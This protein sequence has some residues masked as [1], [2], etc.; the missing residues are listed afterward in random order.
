MYMVCCRCGRV[1]GEP[2]EQNLKYRMCDICLG[3]KNEPPP[4]KR[5]AEPK[6]LQYALFF[7]Y[8]DST[9]PYL[10]RS[11][12]MKPTGV[13]CPHKDSSE[14]GAWCGAWC[15]N[16]EIVEVGRV[17]SGYLMAHIKQWC[18]GRNLCAQVVCEEEPESKPKQSTLAVGPGVA[19]VAG[20]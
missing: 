17:P 4:Q 6:L 1:I 19:P 11:T 3:S 13:F 16:F 14:C 8:D 10:M 2:C 9:A 12:S 5:C 20:Q 7:P 15:A 18:C